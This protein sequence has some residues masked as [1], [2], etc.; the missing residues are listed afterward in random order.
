[1]SDSYLNQKQKKC[2]RIFTWVKI[3]ET[4]Y[5]RS[6]HWIFIHDGKKRDKVHEIEKKHIKNK[7]ETCNIPMQKSFD[8]ILDLLLQDRIL[9]FMIKEKMSTKEN[10]KISKDIDRAKQRK[11]IDWSLYYIREDNIP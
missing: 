9:T 4:I 11:K 2:E 1:M 7:S 5:R 3:Q 6:L 10:R 8:I